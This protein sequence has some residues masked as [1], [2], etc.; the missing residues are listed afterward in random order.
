ML[1]REKKGPEVAKTGL[2]NVSII[3]GAIMFF[4]IPINLSF[5]ALITDVKVLE[6]TPPPRTLTN[7][8]VIS[9]LPLTLR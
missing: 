5:F 9:F 2:A 7:S 1:R 6:S 3:P 8:D 4:N